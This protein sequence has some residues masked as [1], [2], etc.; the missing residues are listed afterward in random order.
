VPDTGPVLALDALLVGASLVS[1][2]IAWKLLRGRISA[3]IAV[4][5][6]GLLILGLGHLSETFMWLAFED[7]GTTT[8]ELAH[9][10]LVMAGFVWLMYGL[11]RTGKELREE[12]DR[13]L[14]TTMALVVTEEDLRLSNEELRQRNSQ[15]LDAYTQA[16]EPERIIRVLVAE[17]NP[18]VRRV[19]SK[20]IA[21]E[22]DMLVAGEAA[23]D[24]EAL[25]AIERH[26]PDVVLVSDVMVRPGLIQALRGAGDSAR[27]VLVLGTYGAGAAGALQAGAHD[28]VL[29]DAGHDRLLMAIRNAIGGHSGVVVE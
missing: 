11:A 18:G 13:L 17:P 25:A 14:K 7:M 1:A 29:K 26:E 22:R 16:Q 9:R 19:L 12:R 4:A 3:G 8:I 2:T 6:L 27:Q 10:V 24:D 28:H 5:C 23:D 21:E 15:L 20:F